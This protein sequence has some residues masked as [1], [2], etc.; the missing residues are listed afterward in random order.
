MTGRQQP[1]EVEAGRSTP[2]EPAGYAKLLE[3]L[4]ARVRVP[5][6]PAETFLGGR[7]WASP[8]RGLGRVSWV[9][10]ASR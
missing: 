8:S 5:F 4:K 1:D 6:P 9:I 3:Q 10:G 7:A 2:E